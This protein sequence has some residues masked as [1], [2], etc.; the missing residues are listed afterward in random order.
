MR[1]KS[2][3]IEVK[4]SADSLDEAIADLES[5]Y[6]RPTRTGGK[7]VQQVTDFR[8]SQ[9][10]HQLIDDWRAGK[11]SYS[12]GDIALVFTGGKVTS[13]ADL[14]VYNPVKGDRFLYSKPPTPAAQQVGLDGVAASDSSIPTSDE[15]LQQLV[16][17]S[18]TLNELTANQRAI[19]ARVERFSALNAIRPINLDAATATPTNKDAI[20]SLLDAQANEFSQRL[21]SALDAQAKSFAQLV[22]NQITSTALHFSERLDAMQAQLNQ[23]IDQVAGFDYDLPDEPANP[24]TEAEWQTRFK[25]AW[26]TVGDYEQYSDSYRAANAA[27]PLFFTPDWIMLCELE[28]ARKGVPTLATLYELIHNAEGIGYEGANILHQFGQHVDA[29][30][31]DRYYIYHRAG[32]NAYEALWQTARNPQNPWLNELQQIAKCIPKRH[33]DVFQMFGWE[34]D[35]IASVDSVVKRVYQEQQAY[36]SRSQSYQQHY[37]AR[38]ADTIS[39]YLTLLNLGPFTPITV[40]SIK[41]AYRQ[42]MKSA[43]PDAGG[44]KE[45]AQTINQAYEAVLQHYFPHAARTEGSQR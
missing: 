8:V 12:P 3:R 36:N 6:V 4:L 9:L 10:C 33:P 13:V 2:L 15:V 34:D 5:C 22:S 27:S 38:T 14:L 18:E 16:A 19:E 1:L 35:A 28:W 26:G 41:R 40:E 44:S 29:A 42:A 23:L 31:G 20:A 39:D 37:H 11:V 30:T 24:Q 43:H 32:F 7:L 21:K 45:L 17:L 25:E